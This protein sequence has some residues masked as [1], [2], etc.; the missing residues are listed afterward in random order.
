MPRLYFSAM[1]IRQGRRSGARSPFRHDR[2]RPLVSYLNPHANAR[3][4]FRTTHAAGDTLGT[5]PTAAT[6]TSPSNTKPCTDRQTSAHRTRR[7]GPAHIK[8]PSPL[9]FRP[10]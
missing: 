8:H 7:V 1:Y 4:R 9:P 3:M 10:H 2:V 6:V 5:L